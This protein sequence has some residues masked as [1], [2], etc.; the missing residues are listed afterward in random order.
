MML[1][2]AEPLHASPAE[3]QAT[4]MDKHQLADLSPLGGNFGM[5]WVQ[6]RKTLSNECVEVLPWVKN[7]ALLAEL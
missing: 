1:A 2:V 5:G 7:P 3:H 6:Y 4:P